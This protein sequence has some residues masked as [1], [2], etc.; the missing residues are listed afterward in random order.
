MITT[1]ASAIAVHMPRSVVTF[2]RVL[3]PMLP[4]SASAVHTAAHGSPTPSDIAPAVITVALS[5]S[6]PPMIRAPAVN[7]VA[8]GSL[9]PLMLPSVHSFDFMQ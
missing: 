3:G 7:T 6:T 5:L 1:T 4:N 8:L 9:T 2:R